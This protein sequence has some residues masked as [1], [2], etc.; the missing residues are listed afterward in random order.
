MSAL[1]QQL[2]LIRAEQ[3]CTR[4]S[5]PAWLIIPFVVSCDQPQ[6]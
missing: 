6:V 5:K 1:G 4:P 2:K 3:V